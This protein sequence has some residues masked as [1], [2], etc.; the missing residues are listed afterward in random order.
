VDLSTHDLG[1]DAAR[2]VD[3]AGYPLGG[4]TPRHAVRPVSRDEIAQVLRAAARDRLT[5]VPWGGGVQLARAG[6]PARYDVALD[7]RA[8]DRVIEYEPEDLTLTAECGISIATLAAAVAAR[9]QELPLEAPYPARATLGGVLAMNTG[10]PRRR[11]LG[12][13]RDRLLGA[14]FVL[15][16]GTLARTGGKVVKNV[17]GHAVHRMLCGSRGT[18]AVLVEASL[19][20]LPAPAR[21]RALVFALPHWALADAAR[22]AAIPRI[23]PSWLTV[24]GRDHRGLVSGVP[25]ADA[26]AVIG[27]EDDGAWVDRQAAIVREALGAPALTLEDGDAIALRAR[28]TDLPQSL[29]PVC[30]R[31]ASAHVTPAALA[32]FADQAWM[33]SAVFH[34]PSGGLWLATATAAE[35]IAALG[36]HG[37]TLID[38]SP[39]GVVAP[40][41]PE[42]SAVR[43]LRARLRA[44]LDPHGVLDRGT[45]S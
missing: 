2:A 19:K 42:A 38:A 16:D 40:P 30:L 44:A 23:E 21:R 17:A 13:P 32:P 12:A 36:L 28:V 18:L 9:G 31:F 7:L 25:D 45:S 39:D 37:F 43:E 41:V 20:L 14:R 4:R 22:W 10:G 24:L 6:A 8:L 27:L 29:G 3:P 1:L 15:G 35:T 26:I 34:A 33:A 11:Q 5:V